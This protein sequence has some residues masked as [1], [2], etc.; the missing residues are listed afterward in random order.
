MIIDD[1]LIAYLEDLSNL[2]L[3]DEEKEKLKCDLQIIL[4]NMNKLSELDATGVP[5][6]SHPFDNVNAFREDVVEPSFDR[7]LILENAPLKN[8]EAFIAPKTVE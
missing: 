6:R 7:G 8:H 2:V 4:N 5:E 3:S 1:K